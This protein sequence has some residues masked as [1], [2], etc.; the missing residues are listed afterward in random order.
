[1]LGFNPKRRIEKYFSRHPE[2]KLIVVAGSFGRASAIRALGHI[3]GQK[4][5]VSVGVNHEDEHPDIVILDFASFAKFPKI[6]PDFM[7]VTSVTSP[8][9]ARAYFDVA[10]RAKHV[11]INRN[12]V[13]GEYAKFLNNPNVITYGDELPANYYFENGDADIYGQTGSLVSPD[14]QKLPVH[15]KILGEH[16][17][18]PIIM[19]FAIAH[20]FEIEHDKIITG[21]RSIRPLHGH[22]SPGRGINNAIIIDDSADTS[23]LSVELALRT[24]YLL[25]A[26]SRILI[27][28]KFDPTIAIDRD[29]IS[30]VLIFDPSAHPQTDPIFHIFHSEIDLLE[31]LGKRLEPDAIVLLEYPLPN[32]TT[33]K[34][35]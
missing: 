1:M 9:E 6:T 22:L 20:L 21:V 19:A 26:P 2:V 16:N 25:S 12:D 34:I 11:L 3:L 29:L 32:I 14:G 4:F 8:T 31:H 23:R 7:V 10:N 27:T 24:I 35:L 17:L 13:P 18:R 15:V 5:I 28:G 30:E 33:S